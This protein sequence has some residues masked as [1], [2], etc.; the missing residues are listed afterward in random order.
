MLSKLGFQKRK[1]KKKK[2]VKVRLEQHKLITLLR[3]KVLK[4]YKGYHIQLQGNFSK[5]NG[6]KGVK[7]T[8]PLNKQEKKS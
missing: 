2:G 5:G 8:K 1:K 3:K 7:N 4:D 6:K